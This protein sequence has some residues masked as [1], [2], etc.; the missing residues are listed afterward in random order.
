MLD[1]LIKKCDFLNELPRP[2]H[3]GTSVSPALSSRSPTSAA[4]R[5]VTYIRA[6]ATS[7]SKHYRPTRS[8]QAKIYAFAIDASASGPSG[9]IQSTPSRPV[10]TLR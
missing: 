2:D 5:S 3:Q 10:Q 7:F 9:S 1:Q 4:T 6:S 8:E